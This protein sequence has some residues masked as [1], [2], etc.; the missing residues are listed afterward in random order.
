MRV[1][2]QL[3][4]WLFVPLLVPSM[5]L[6]LLFNLEAASK[7]AVDLKDNLFI[8]NNSLQFYILIIFLLLTCIAPG[9]SILI[10]KRKGRVK[11][12]EL[13]DRE[14]RT[15]PIIITGFYAILLAIVLFKQLPIRYFPF[16]FHAM[17]VLGI[18]SS[19]VALAISQFTKISLHAMTASMAAGT[20]IFYY[21]HFY[22]PNIWILLLVILLGGV[23]M[24]ARYYLRKHTLAQLVSGY[25]IGLILS[26]S[27]FSIVNYFA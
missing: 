11:S 9:V 13:N 1:L 22:V 23:V 6:L 10:M 2:S 27:M 21:A 5:T 4:S 18:V 8:M 19:L 15:F 17:A 20:V 24:S 14:E 26:L 3:I 7:T 25:L 16:I 12:I